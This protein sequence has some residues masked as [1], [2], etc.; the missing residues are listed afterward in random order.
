[1]TT[2]TRISVNFSD[3]SEIKFV[4]D[5]GTKAQITPNINKINMLRCPFFV[6]S[7]PVAGQDG[8]NGCDREPR[9][10]CFGFGGE[11]SR[12]VMKDRI[13]TRFDAYLKDRA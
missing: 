8:T 2:Y 9:Y 4:R 11:S 7:C 1:M 10:R 5:N 6:P 13:E 12:I 3:G